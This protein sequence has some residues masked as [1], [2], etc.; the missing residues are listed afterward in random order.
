MLTF[1]HRDLYIFIG[2]SQSS[3]F[4]I[5]GSVKEAASV[6]PLL[7]LGV[8]AGEVEADCAGK[9]SCA[10]RGSLYCHFY[11]LIRCSFYTPA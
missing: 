7:Y 4:R 5:W 9:R 11:L 6:F 3:Y 10:E 8:L 2:I 1:L